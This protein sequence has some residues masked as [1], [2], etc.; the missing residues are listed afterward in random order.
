MRGQALQIV[1]RGSDKIPNHPESIAVL[2]EASLA[3]PQGEQ[4]KEGGG[5]PNKI[6]EVSQSA[7]DMRS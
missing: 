2:H 5:P 3:S 7:R 1:E 4:K 6:F